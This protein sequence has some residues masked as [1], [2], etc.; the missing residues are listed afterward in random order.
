MKVIDLKTPYSR[1]SFISFFRD[2][3]LPEDFNIL[4]EHISFGFQSNYFQTDWL[5]ITCVMI[6][7]KE[8]TRQRVMVAP[9][10]KNSTTLVSRACQL[11]QYS[12]N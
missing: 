11:R 1:N 9:L 7:L 5:L 4:D 10:V 8:S 12:E 2:H 6:G 3:L